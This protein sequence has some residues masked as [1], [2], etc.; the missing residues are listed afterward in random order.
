MLL[1]LFIVF[2]YLFF[3]VDVNITDMAYLSSFDRY[4]NGSECASDMKE[5]KDC[6]LQE[7]IREEST[8]I[9]NKVKWRRETQKQS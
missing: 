6:S 7:E 2:I 4:K 5:P 1:G 9:G 8:N 3:F